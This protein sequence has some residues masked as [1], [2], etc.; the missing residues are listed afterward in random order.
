[1]LASDLVAEKASL[2]SRGNKSYP[3]VMNRGLTLVELLVSIAV[4]G[5][6]AATGI[7]YLLSQISTAREVEGRLLVTE[8]MRQQQ[9][10]YIANLEFAE[11]D[12]LQPPT[13]SRYL[14]II[15]FVGLG[16]VE[17][18]A[19]TDEERLE[20]FCGSVSNTEPGVAQSEVLLEFEG[21]EVCD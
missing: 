5:I 15:S 9:R 17:I 8:L 12:Q 1:M 21:P 18:Q 20:D 2:T 3:C 16:K 19:A 4:V 13:T 14:P 10:H 11:L 7:P 6:L